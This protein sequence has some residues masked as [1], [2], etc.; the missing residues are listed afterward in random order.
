MEFL[1]VHDNFYM[2]SKCG[3]PFV[4]VTNLISDLKLFGHVDLLTLRRLSSDICIVHTNFITLKKSYDYVFINSFFSFNTLL[5]LFIFRKSRILI[6][7]RGELIK[8]VVFKDGQKIA[9]KLLFIKTIKF[10]LR[11]IS[12][13][14]IFGV[15]NQ[16]ESNGLDFF[17][18]DSKR[19]ILPN[20]MRLNEFNV[21]NKYKYLRRNDVL[22]VVFFSRIDLK[23]NL[24][25]TFDVL[26]KSN[27]RVVLDVYGEAGSQS[28]NDYIYKL[29]NESCNANFIINFKGHI[30]F[31]YFKSIADH[32]HLSILHTAGENF[33]HSIV[34]SFL[35]GIP[36]LLSTNTPW[37]G[38]AEKGVG[39]DVPLSD[40]ERHINIVSDLEE[41]VLKLDLEKRASFL[42]DLLDSLSTADSIGVLLNEK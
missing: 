17:F 11:N 19:F 40:L 15:T 38:L 35:L 34:E 32:Y 20:A 42:N 10:S 33:G 29:A 39:W 14:V 23:K 36:T 25:Y 26:L 3:G 9:K 2:G 31:D 16:T 1:V 7:P 12:R 30:E 37:R 13:R 4:S 6:L 24:E 8:D 18:R 28:Y 27:R 41:N 21:F 22:N 5:S